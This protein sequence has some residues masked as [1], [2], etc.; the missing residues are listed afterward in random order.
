MVLDLVGMERTGIGPADH[1]PF[2]GGW[3][4]GRLGLPRLHQLPDPAQPGGA[5][6]WRQDRDQLAPGAVPVGA[7]HTDAPCREVL[8]VGPGPLRQGAELAD[9]RVEGGGQ[10]PAAV[11]AAR[12]HRLGAGGQAPHQ[13]ERFNRVGRGHQVQDGAALGVQLGHERLD[14]LPV[15][16]RRGPGDASQPLGDRARRLG[17]AATPGQRQPQATLRGG[18]AAAD[19]DQQRRELR[20]AKRFEVRGVERLAGCHGTECRAIRPRPQR[21]GACL[22]SA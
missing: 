11:V 7:Q 2:A 22:S 17:R 8:G 15:Q 6:L 14:L 20:C 10:A 13:L 16:P 18:V 19:L 12:E 5:E 3:R 21:P 4:H 1:P 9:R